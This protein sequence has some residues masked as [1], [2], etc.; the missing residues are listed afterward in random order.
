MV[1][2]TADSHNNQT[3]QVMKQG[4]GVT[5]SNMRVTLSNTRLFLN[6]MFLGWVL[7]IQGPAQVTSFFITKY[8][9]TKS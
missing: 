3:A 1:L 4:N 5:E 2:K 6:Q 7:L 9:I 8:F